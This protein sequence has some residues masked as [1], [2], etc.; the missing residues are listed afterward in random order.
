MFTVIV[1]D[2]RDSEAT[3]PESTLGDFWTLEQA[4]N[5]LQKYMET[6][7]GPYI[8]RSQIIEKE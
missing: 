7:H 3:E 8:F 6:E 5:A 4:E 1:W 2:I